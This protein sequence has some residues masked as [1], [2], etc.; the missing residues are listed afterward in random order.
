MTPPAYRSNR[1]ICFEARIPVQVEASTD[2][3][4]FIKSYFLR[5][6]S[7]ECQIQDI[8]EYAIAEDRGAFLGSLQIIRDRYGTLWLRREAYV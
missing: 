8:E 4:E 7:Q 3:S 2:L 5:G 6:G 1:M